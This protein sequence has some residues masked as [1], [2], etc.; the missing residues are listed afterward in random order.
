MAARAS[1][2][3]PYRKFKFKIKIGGQVVAGLTKCSALTVSVES[4]EYRT[5][6]MDS[7][8]QK[9]PGMVSFEAIT[10]DQGVTKDKTFEA[11]ATAM[12]NYLGNKGSDSQKTP[13]DFR[14][15]IDI[16][17]YNLNNERVKAYRVYQCWVSKYVAVPDL[18]AN[19]ADVMI[20]TITLENEGIQV[21]Q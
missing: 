4:K 1:Q 19:S 10:L 11:W 7:F 6:D 16:E 20:Q 15:D 12:S 8:K 14:K 21:M 17:I 3:D 2:F 13:N 9:L 5:G 18:D